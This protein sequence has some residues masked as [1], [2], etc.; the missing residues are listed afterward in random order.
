MGME[1]LQVLMLHT[2]MMKQQQT[3]LLICTRQQG[4]SFLAM[5][6]HNVLAFSAFK[7]GVQMSQKIMLYTP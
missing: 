7:Q 1:A 6:R 4:N 5:A 3:Q 2:S